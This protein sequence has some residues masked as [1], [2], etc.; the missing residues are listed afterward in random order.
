MRVV[1]RVVDFS[2]IFFRGALT[3]RSSADA[4]R[5]RARSGGIPLPLR[6]WL[7]RRGPVRIP[8]LKAS[9][10]SLPL[11]SGGV[12]PG[13][14]G[15]SLADRCC[16]F[17]LCQTMS[18]CTS[19]YPDRCAK[20]HRPRCRAYRTAAT[21]DSAPSNPRVRLAPA[22]CSYGQES[23]GRKGSHALFSGSC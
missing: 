19:S 21:G 7:E 10:F 22:S 18:S 13:V 1:K 2:S 8:I 6:R 16:R 14:H 15:V 3:A 5:S 23:P 9:C 11:R 17:L 20:A 4:E 12:L